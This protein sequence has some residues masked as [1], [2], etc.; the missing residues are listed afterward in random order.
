MRMGLPNHN[1][2]DSREACSSMQ[3]RCAATLILVILLNVVSAVRA[4]ERTEFFETRIRPQLMKHCYECHSVAS[5]TAEGGL[6]IDSREESLNLS[7]EPCPG[8]TSYLVEWRE[9]ETDFESEVRASKT[10]LFPN[11]N[12]FHWLFPLPAVS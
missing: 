7:W 5:S 3:S 8:A 10:C 2:G 1:S 11:H 4:D 12:I 6:K 9:F